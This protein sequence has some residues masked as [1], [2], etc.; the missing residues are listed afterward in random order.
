MK[1][2]GA[3]IAGIFALGLAIGSFGSGSGA[4]PEPAASALESAPPLHQVDCGEGREALL[5]PF[6]TQGTASFNVRCI[7]TEKKQ[8]PR[9]VSHPAP[10]AP[11]PAVALA[12]PPP[13]PPP[14]K[15]PT[16]EPPTP[17][18]EV[19]VTEPAVNEPAVNEPAVNEPAV[20][21]IDLDDADD[22]RSWK[23]RAVVIGG[24]AGAGAG[25]GAIAKGKKGAAV[26]AAIG[27]ASGAAYEWIK[28]DKKN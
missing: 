23:E 21:E 22:S 13:E 7:D 28:R 4:R 14:P 15:P 18:R 27:A 26:G 9:V 6:D 1:T 25:I 19:P 16:P 12:P 11:A 8:R 5:E 2:L 24:A 17:E 3:W 20:N 10:R